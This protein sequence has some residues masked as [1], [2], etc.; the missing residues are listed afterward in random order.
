MEMGV[1]KIILLTHYQFQN[2]LELGRNLTGVDVIVGGDSHTLLGD[3]Y[4]DLGQTVAGSY[5]TVVTN[6][7]GDEVCVVQAWQYA[8]ILGELNVSFDADGVVTN[9]EGT[10]HM[11]LANTFTRE[12]ADGEEYSPEGAELATLETAIDA[13]DEL[14]ITEEDAETVAVLATFSEKVDELKQQVIGSA[15]EDLCLERI[16]GQGRSTICDASETFS[17][18]SD[19]SNIVSKAFL[20]MSNTSDICIQNG[21]GVR[22]DVP[23]GDISYDTAYTLLPFANTLVEIEM[24][25]QQI[26]DTLEEAAIAT[27]DGSSGAYPYASGLRWNVDLS[28]AEGERFS[29]VEINSRVSSEWTAIDTSATYKVVTNSFIAAGGDGYD[30][31][32]NIVD[33][34]KTDTFLDYALSFVEYVEAETAAGNTIAKLP[35]A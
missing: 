28:A 15:A 8:S 2:D 35:I 10:P 11:P 34:L 30:T 25:G 32:G 27:L 17:N 20:E 9:C 19:I 16:P 14:S 6:L 12:D 1:N 21:G 4:V 3:A 33:E 24:T 5:P 18:G 26:I 29:S 7:D 22:I 13:M 31:F 23:A